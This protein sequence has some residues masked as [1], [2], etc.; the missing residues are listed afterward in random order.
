[1]PPPR[2]P[3]MAPAMSFR[4]AVLAMAVGCAGCASFGTFVGQGDGDVVYAEEPEENLKRGDQ[5]L[6]SKSHT[7]A[8]KYYEYV[9]TK[10]PYLEVSKTAELKLADTDFDRERFIEARERYLGFVRLHP[11]HAQVD[12]AAFRAALSHYKDIPSDFFLLPPSAEKDQ[13]EVKS[14]LVAMNEFVRQYPSSSYVPEAQKALVDVKRRLAKHELYA[15]D[16]YAS[17]AKWAAVVSRLNVVAAQY[18]GTGFEERVYLGLYEAHTKLSQPEPAKAALRV[19]IARQPGTS[20]AQRAQRL[21]GPDVAPPAPT[22]TPEPA[23]APAPAA[24]AKD[25]APQEPATQ[26]Q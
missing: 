26:L 3:P 16:F 5:A 15:A 22:P 7:E 14:A 1:M 23:P 20:A 13:G 18:D 17:R 8:Q 11:T 12:Y 21:L 25:G 19:L 2:F 9:K 24:P 4:S 10:F 6:A